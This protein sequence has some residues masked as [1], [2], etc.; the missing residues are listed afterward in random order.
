MAKAAERATRLPEGA[1]VVIERRPTCNALLDDIAKAA[2][3]RA[4]TEEHVV[5]AVATGARKAEPNQTQQQPTVVAC[6][7]QH[8]RMVRAHLNA[9]R[10]VV[11]D[12]SFDNNDVSAISGC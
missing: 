10:A 2:K 4:K 11:K 12:E 3:L 7:V 1:P 6:R 8:D 5:E 9:L